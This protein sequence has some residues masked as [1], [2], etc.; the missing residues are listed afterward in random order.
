MLRMSLVCIRLGSILEY[1][2]LDVSET[3][4]KYFKWTSDNNIF[5]TR[6]VM[7]FSK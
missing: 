2:E 5:D 3:T 7:Y 6:Y 1:T 4:V